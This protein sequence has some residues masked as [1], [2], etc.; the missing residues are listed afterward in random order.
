MNYFISFLFI[1]LGCFMVV[2]TEWILNFFDYSAWA[3]AKFGAW[4]GSRTL[5]KLIGLII[6]IL[7]LMWMTGW[8]QDI[9]ISI[10]N[11]GR[12]GGE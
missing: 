4:G 5:Y 11:P 6:I 12:I 2:K 3:E 9:L 10:F 1:A 8:L 7:A